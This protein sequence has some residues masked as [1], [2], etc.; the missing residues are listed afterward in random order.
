MQDAFAVLFF[1]SVGMLIDPTILLQQPGRVAATV[2]VI[3]LGNAVAASVL[4]VLLGHSLRAS[5]RLGASL[6]QIGEFSFIL[7]G[8][9]VSIGVLTDDGRSLIL[10]AALVTIVLN[11]LLFRAMDALGVLISRRPKLL[12]RL[13][14]QREPRMMAT[15]VYAAMRPDHAILVGY[16]RVGRTIGDALHRAGIPFVAVEGERRV[17]EAMR[18]L[19]VPVI[20][21]D[22]TQSTVFSQTHPERAKLLVIATPDPYQ[23]RHIVS[24]ARARNPGIQIIVRTHSD[25]EQTLFEGLGAKALM[26]ERELSYG[27]AHQSLRMLGCDDDRADDVLTSLRGGGRMMTQEFSSLMPPPAAPGRV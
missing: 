11:P 16:G 7:A 22:A 23:A 13:E 10:A 25:E 14:R 24:M 27:M 26:G 8:L 17:V 15:D 21:G 2:G 5:L 19:G 18:T 20:Y 9:G 6:G 1:V 4:M 3:W 12:D